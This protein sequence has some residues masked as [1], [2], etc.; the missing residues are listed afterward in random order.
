MFHK[1]LVAI[2]GIQ[3]IFGLMGFQ[4]NGPSDNKADSIIQANR[5]LLSLYNGRRWN[6][7]YTHVTFISGTIYTHHM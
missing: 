2:F 3:L 5:L 4:T 6:D 7:V 1:F